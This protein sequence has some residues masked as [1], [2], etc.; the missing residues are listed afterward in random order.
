MG[1]RHRLR[2]DIT[3]VSLPQSSIKY[4]YEIA[5]ATLNA[6]YSIIGRAN[7]NFKEVRMNVEYHNGWK[8]VAF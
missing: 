4:L 6:N 5:E 3:L 2:F 8:S 7:I 1:E